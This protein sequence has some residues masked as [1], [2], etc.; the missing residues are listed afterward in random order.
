MAD[1]KLKYG[2]AATIT[3]SLSNLANN[4]ARQSVVVSN[5]T[6]LY[7]DNLVV[8]KLKTGNTG[9]SATGFIN[10][11]VYGS[12]N[13]GTTYSDGATGSDAAITLTSPPNVRTIGIINA[14]AN[15][16]TYVGGPYSVA[17][18]FGGMLPKQWGV[19]V[20]NKCG[21]SLS[22]TEGNHGKLRQGI[23]IQSA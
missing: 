2:T 11:Y 21:A 17:A 9:S 13:E 23:L 10:I 8:M 20:E 3:I 15:N 18:A 5:A 22:I 14:V 1:V 4:A 12:A 7:L 19:I 16:V 6:D